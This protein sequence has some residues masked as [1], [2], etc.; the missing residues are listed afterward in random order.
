MIFIKFWLIVLFA[1]SFQFEATSQQNWRLTKE[2][3][4][5]KVFMASN[6]QSKFK[7]IRVQCVFD[8]TIPKLIN[9]IENVSKHTDWVYKTKKAYVLKRVSPSEFIYYSESIMP[10]PLSNRDGAFDLSLSYDTTNK[11]LRIKAFA[12]PNFIAT[13][14]GL[15]RIPYLKSSWYVSEIKN[16]LI[17]DYIFEV[18]PGG[19]I[20]AWLVNLFAD[21]GPY[22]SFQKLA[23][24][25]KS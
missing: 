10:W 12:E 16:Q 11:V 25:L 1:L 18:D 13:K 7:S 4:G 14:A 21:K 3:N 15:V 24:L 8:G 20:P 6:K 9:I 19:S 22:E 17:I 2:N 23:R 5:I